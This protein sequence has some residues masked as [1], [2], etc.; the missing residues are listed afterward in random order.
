MGAAAS[1]PIGD[2]NFGHAYDYPSQIANGIK[3]PGGRRAQIGRH[4]TMMTLGGA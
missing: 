3:I 4:R 1:M 2:A